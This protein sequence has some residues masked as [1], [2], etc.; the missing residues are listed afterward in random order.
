M[1][2]RTGGHATLETG[3]KP[4]INDLARIDVFLRKGGRHQDNRNIRASTTRLSRTASCTETYWHWV[5]TLKIQ[6]FVGKKGQGARQN[7]TNSIANTEYKARKLRDSP[8][9]WMSPECMLPGGHAERQL[10][11]E[12]RPGRPFMVFAEAHEHP[13]LH[14]PRF[15]FMNCGGIGG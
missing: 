2:H 6:A 8:P 11:Q 7:L 12:I 4:M 5:C 1:D 3:T 14:V 13:D 9:I 10:R 15:P